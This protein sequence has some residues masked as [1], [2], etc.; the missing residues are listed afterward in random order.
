[1]RRLAGNLLMGLGI[2]GAALTVLWI[3]VELLALPHDANEDQRTARDACVLF[4]GAM[5]AVEVV[6][7]LVG[8]SLRQPQPDEVAEPPKQRSGRRRWLLVPYLIVSV[9]I[10]TLAAFLPRT[11]WEGIEPLGLLVCQPHILV[12]FIGGGLLGIKLRGDE[13]QHAVT[14]AA[15]LL[16]FPILFYPLYR[17]FAMDRK[18]EVKAYTLMRVVLALFL[19]AHILI[20]LFLLVIHQA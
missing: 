12:Q 18:A 7:F 19:G 13:L 20:A 14:V 11:V 9:G 6:A 3:V 5:L 4:A 2:V 1:M 17:I 16:Y 10:G 15:N 8:W